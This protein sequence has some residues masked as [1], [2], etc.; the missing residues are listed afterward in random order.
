M[1]IFDA[2]SLAISN[3]FRTK[4]RSFLTILGVVIGIT[5]IVLFVS[6]GVGLQRTT[7]DQIAGIDVLTTLTITQAPQT[8]SLEEGPKLTQ[9]SLT[10]FGKIKG[11][12]DVSPSVN[13]PA[14]VTSSGTSTGAMV[15]GIDTKHSSL[16]I[17]A[18]SAGQLVKGAQDAVISRAL[19]IALS[20]TPD[21]A[22]GK[23][24]TIDI[25]RNVDGLNYQSG[26]LQYNIVGVDNNDTANS[27]YVPIDQIYQAGKFASY[28]SVKV[29]VVSTSDIDSVKSGIQSL[30]YVVTT[31]KDLIDQID[32]IFLIAEIIL[33]LIGGIGLFVSALGIINT[34]TI[35]FL[36]R[37]KEIGIMKAVGASDKDIR[38][39]FMIESGLIGF[40]GGALGIGLALLVEYLFNAVLNYLIRS[41]GQTLYLFTTP[42]KFALIMVVIS[43]AISI[44]AGFYPTRRAQ[45]LLPIEAMRQ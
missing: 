11:V 30:G 23:Q 39:L 22:V 8:A 44:A 32:K 43:V 1:R 28:S 41:S 16:E 27:V 29:K 26:Q 38:K 34:M 40:I 4:F 24:I 10:E 12:G 14:N 45:R 37:T 3:L 15:Y 36:E 18:L 2:I 21:N 42:L 17:S 35:S 19:A 20:P 5:A 25:V 13:L 6:L 33:G 31:I 7:S 9:D